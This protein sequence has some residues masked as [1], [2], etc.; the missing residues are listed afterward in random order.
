MTKAQLKEVKK[1][2][3]QH[4]KEV[5]QQEK[6]LKQQAKQVAKAAKN[7]RQVE[8]R[9][10]KASQKQKQG[11]RPEGLSPPASPPQLSSASPSRVAMLANLSPE[12]QAE[13]KRQYD[14]RRERVVELLKVP[15]N[16]ICADCSEPQPRWCL[17]NTGVFVCIKCSGIHRSFGAHISKVRSCLLD[18]LEEEDV[19]N[20]SENGNAKVNLVEATI[21]GGLKK[22]GPAASDEERRRW[23]LAKYHK[24]GAISE[25]ELPALSNLRSVGTTN[26]MTDYGALLVIKLYGA[27]GLPAADLNGTSDPYVLFQ[28]GRQAIK[29]KV[30]QKSLSPFWDETIRICIPSKSDQLVLSVWDKDSMT[31]DF[32]GEITLDLSNLQLNS[33]EKVVL[34]LHKKAAKV[35]PLPP[36]RVGSPPPPVAVAQPSMES[37]RK[38]KRRK[39]DKS[40][41]KSKGLGTVHLK[42]TLQE[43]PH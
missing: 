27:K 8:K 16:D 5:K 32:L 39:K 2:E 25:K 26:A 31:D 3:K 42:L 33:P 24:L 11:A 20:L 4:E 41:K 23:L 1:Q 28:C 43:L 14:A 34:P 15:G 19:K 37:L 17:V 21:E 13:R 10:A 38:G 7:R 36:Y 40:K 22:I 30:V 12:E 35:G 6:D 9:Q 29:S 18:E